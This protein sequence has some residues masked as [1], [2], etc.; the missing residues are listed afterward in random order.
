[1]PFL[2]PTLLNSIDLQCGHRVLNSPTGVLI[3]LLSV[4][5]RRAA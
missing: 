5:L 1:M 4:S 3:A 2:G